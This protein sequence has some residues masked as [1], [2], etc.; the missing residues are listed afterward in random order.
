MNYINLPIMMMMTIM[1]NDDNDDYVEDN[2]V[3][4]H[5]DDYDD[6]CDDNNNVTYLY[7]AKCQRPL[8]A[9]K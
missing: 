4:N 2:Y 3:G 6:G 1:I 9:S 7:S 8:S 5:A